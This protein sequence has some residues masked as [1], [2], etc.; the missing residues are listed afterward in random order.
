MMAGRKPR[1]TDAQVAS[2]QRMRDNGATLQHVADEHGCSVSFIHTHTINHRK[3]D[4]TERQKKHRRLTALDK[5]RIREGWRDLMTVEDIADMMQVSKSVVSKYIK[6]VNDDER[7][8]KPPK[9]PRTYAEQER[10][11][12][13]LENETIS[14]DERRNNAVPLTAMATTAPI[15]KV[16]DWTIV[17]E[18]IPDE[19]WDVTG[20]LPD[21]ELSLYAQDVID[22][23]I[24]AVGRGRIFAEQ[25]IAVAQSIYIYAN[26]LETWEFD[27][28]LERRGLWVATRALSRVNSTDLAARLGISPASISRYESGDRAPERQMLHRIHDA[29]CALLE[30]ALIALEAQL[31]LRSYNDWSRDS[32]GDPDNDILEAEPLYTWIAQGTDLEDFSISHID[33]LVTVRYMLSYPHWR[34]PTSDNL[35]LK[36]FPNQPSLVPT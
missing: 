29:Y 30:E 5:E 10:K 33:H 35:W 1:F 2:M 13:A 34:E 4:Q 18:P 8:P 26:S 7:K 12:W 15:D 21:N 25:P 32:G 36:G 9:P 3:Q 11:L 19:G 16:L 14:E 27:T 28:F 17:N 22:Q 24:R 20:P 23:W 31:I 6:D